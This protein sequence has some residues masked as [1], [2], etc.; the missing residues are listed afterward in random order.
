[1]QKYHLKGM[2]RTLPSYNIAMPIFHGPYQHS[3]HSWQICH[4]EEICVQQSDQPRTYFLV[5][6]VNYKTICETILWIRQQTA[7]FPQ[8]IRMSKVCC[9]ECSKRIASPLERLV[10]RR[11]WRV[12]HWAAESRQNVV[13]RRRG[14]TDPDFRAFFLSHFFNRQRHKYVQD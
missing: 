6:Q 2:S 11:S 7:S 9:T 14:E 10:C 8:S 12:C 13:R 4:W 3:H 1:M 5:L